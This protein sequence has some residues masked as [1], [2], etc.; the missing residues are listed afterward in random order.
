MKKEMLKVEK[1]TL[2]NIHILILSTCEYVVSHGNK[3]FVK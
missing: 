1:W 2:K 3:D